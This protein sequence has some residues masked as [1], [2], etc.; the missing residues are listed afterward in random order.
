V[1]LLWLYSIYREGMKTFPANRRLWL[2]CTIF[3]TNWHM[4]LQKR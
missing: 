3:M 1:A 4:H 2:F